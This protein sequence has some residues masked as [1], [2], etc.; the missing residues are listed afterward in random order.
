MKK[1]NEHTDSSELIFRT[2]LLKPR[3]STATPRGYL[4]VAVAAGPLVMPSSPSSLSANVLRV[5]TL[6]QGRY[7]TYSK[8]F[9]LHYMRNG[10]PPGYLFSQSEMKAPSQL[11]R[12]VEGGQ[13]LGRWRESKGTAKAGHTK[14]AGICLLRREKWVK[15]A[16]S[17][18]SRGMYASERAPTPEKFST[19]ISHLRS[20]RGF[21]THDAKWKPP[22]DMQRS[23][24]NGSPPATRVSFRSPSASPD[25]SPC[26]QRES[27]MPAS[28]DKRSKATDVTT[29]P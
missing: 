18:R 9:W 25:T 24:R 20:R 4:N 5:V 22:A 6:S 3:E 21:K 17:L 7:Q 8:G 26:C 2:R 12:E 19:L 11:R 15:I 14:E 1:H 29:C 23:M 10:S 27:S 16:R 13:R 28:A